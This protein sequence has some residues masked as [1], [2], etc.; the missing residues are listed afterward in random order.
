MHAFDKM[1]EPELKKLFNHIGNLLQKELPENTGWI[2]LAS[3]FD[4][5]IAQ[6]VSNTRREV[7][8]A[9]MEETLERWENDDFVSR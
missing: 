6:Y 3:P 9:W 4:S 8:S 2:L 5:G 1:T 7:A